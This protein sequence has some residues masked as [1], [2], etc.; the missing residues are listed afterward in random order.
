MYKNITKNILLNQV[1]SNI[2]KL[3][4]EV[5]AGNGLIIDKLNIK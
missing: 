3:K 5:T 1:F 4:T 2:L